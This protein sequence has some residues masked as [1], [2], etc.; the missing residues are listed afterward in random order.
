MFN[1][2]KP[3]DITKALLKAREDQQRKDE[4][5]IKELLMIQKERLDRE[6][7]LK[8]QDKDAEIMLLNQEIKDMKYKVKN[9]IDLE[10]KSSQQIQANVAIATQIAQQ[11]TQ[12][13]LSIERIIGKVHG[14]KTDAELH[15]NTIENK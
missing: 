8:L 12:F 6:Y 13:S 14:I 7:S 2:F 15:R 1:L 5:K 11:M 10:Y 4:L 9:A 3:K